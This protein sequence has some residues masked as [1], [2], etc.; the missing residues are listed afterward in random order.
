MNVEL[1]V[2]SAY[3]GMLFSLKMKGSSDTGQN[4]ESSTRNKPVPKG[5]D[6]MTSTHMRHL[7]QS[8]SWRQKGKGQCQ[9]LGGESGGFC[10]M[11]TEVQFCKVHKEF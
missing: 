7:Q 8:N 5:Q 9:G 4:M 10:S 6:Y 3:E 2:A 11:G 1:N